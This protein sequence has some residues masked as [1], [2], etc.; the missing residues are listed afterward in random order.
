MTNIMLGTN[1]DVLV[2][3]PQLQVFMN[4]VS[5]FAQALWKIQTTREQSP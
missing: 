5:E 2:N 4:K 3:E 1:P